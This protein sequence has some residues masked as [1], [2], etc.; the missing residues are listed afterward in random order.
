MPA[1][2]KVIGIIASGNRG[3]FTLF[4]AATVVMSQFPALL[5]YMSKIIIDSLVAGSSTLHLSGSGKGPVFWG[6][7]YLLLLLVQFVGQIILY[8]LNENLTEAASR[9][10]HTGIIKTAVRL[11]GLYYFDDPAFHNRRSLLSNM[12]LYLPMNCL[13]FLAD[14]CSI[15]V[16]IAS[17]GGLLF[18]LHPLVPILIVIAGIPDILAQKKAHR[19]IYE[20][21]KETAH[22]QRMK[23]YYRSVLLTDQ[24]VKE[25]RVYNLKN[26]FLNK[27]KN[28]M[29]HILELVV[30]LRQK[31]IRS[32]AFSRLLLSLGTILPYLWAIEEALRGRVTP[33]QLLMFMTAIV[34]IQQQLSRT[35]QTLA[36]HQDIVNIM[37]ELTA[38]VQM[39]PDLPVL[40][41][42]LQKTR[43]A[44]VPPHVRIEDLWFKYPGSS[45]F[46][47]KGLDL[48]IKRGKSL[49]IVGKNGS[50]KTTMVKLL[51]RLYDPEK[52]SIYFDNINIRE[53]RIPD[54]RNSVGVIF[55]D[56]MQYYLTV[57]ENITL[58][59][60]TDQRSMEAA[61]RAA[62]I[63]GADDFIQ[64]LAKGYDSLLGKHFPGGVELSA[65]Q[66]Q[67]LALARALFRNGG[68]L[69][70][71][72][73]T[74]ALDIATEARIYS[75]FKMMTEGKTSLLVSHRLSTV[76]IA[77]YIAVIDDGKVIEYGDHESLMCSGGT[78]NE[79]F[80]TQAERYRLQD[81]GA[82]CRGTAS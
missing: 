67:R 31:Q 70:L 27:Y 71:D 59:D 42:K 60:L 19:L 80:M 35:A 68:M 3:L 46:V 51:C 55:Q 14:I 17:M 7:V 69:I 54:L 40:D 77:D 49:A 30:P 33:G 81:E 64:P 23:E 32:S 8:F 79:M 37:G 44:H 61:Q 53:I 29:G 58:Q 25:V 12:A 21:V 52:G 66:W 34:V 65:G 50:G 78:Y 56:F 63:A 28:S 22:E 72:E 47:L 2:L 41:E 75:D 6:S 18:G 82:L 10:I 57:K 9:N 20:G 15:A 4:V 1:V 11:Q 45:S 24:Y 43:I 38:W 16:S 74:A 48:E 26:Y 39:K 73:P 13:R 62:R 5:A 76:R 36:G